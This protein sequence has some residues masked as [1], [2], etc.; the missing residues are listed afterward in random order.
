MTGKVDEAMDGYRKIKKDESDNASINEARLNN[1]GYAL[2]RQK[3][4]AEAIAIFK[5]NVEFYP[6]C[7]EHLRQF[8]RS[9]HE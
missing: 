9:L 5:L 6:Q 3:K 8:R 2:M 4:M 1:L 7:L